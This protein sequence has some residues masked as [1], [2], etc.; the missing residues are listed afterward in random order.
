MKIRKN[1]LFYLSLIALHLVLLSASCSD[2]EDGTGG[3]SGD[4]TKIWAI[5]DT[6][7]GCSADDLIA[8]TTLYE[9]DRSGL[10]DLKAVMVD[11]MGLSSLQVTDIMNTYYGCS[12]VEIGM[13]HDG[14]QN[15]H[16]FIDYW[17]MADPGTYTGE[18]TFRRT[19]SDAQLKALP[20]AEELYRKL[21]SQAK[22]QSVVIFSVGF[23][24]NLSHLLQS[25][26]D[27]YSPLSGV[28][29]VRRKVKALYVQGGH[30]G[31]AMEPDFNFSQDKANAKVLMEKWPVDMYFSPME[32]GE[33]FE[34]RPEAVLADLEK[35][36]QAD[37]PLYHVYSHHNCNTGQRMWDV[38]A[39]LQYLHPE[40]F[41]IYGPVQY[42]VDDDMVLHEQEG[43]HHYMTTVS[44]DHQRSV[45]ME[46]I[47]KG[48]LA[49]LRR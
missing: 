21:L 33:L 42:T 18:P 6:D 47:R 19:F 28:E 7:I 15:P 26:G 49:G 4:Q 48:A 44:N 16:V 39:V 3:Q 41:A 12:D 10:L 40:N 34:Y 25:G 17:K 37:S 5:I 31:Q 24:T 35:A 13:V 30:F 11:R 20:A 8:L 43:T 27:E 1:Q 14:V 2:E 23:V 46:Y 36:G 29:L 32:T 9:A 38:C 22:D 45:V